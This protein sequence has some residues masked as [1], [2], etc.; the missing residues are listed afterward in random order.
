MIELDQQI[1]HLV[2]QFNS[3]GFQQFTT[4]FPYIL[5]EKDPFL[6]E[7][8]KIVKFLTQVNLFLIGLKIKMCVR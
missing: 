1:F 7:V 4:L 8:P 2:C 6:R 5:R 3:S